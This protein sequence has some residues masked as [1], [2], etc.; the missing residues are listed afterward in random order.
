MPTNF[1]HLWIH[2]RNI[3]WSIYFA[4]N[5]VANGAVDIKIEETAPP[6]KELIVVCPCMERL[7]SRLLE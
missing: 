6:L 2:S 4:Q 1:T 3:F 5:T 7:V